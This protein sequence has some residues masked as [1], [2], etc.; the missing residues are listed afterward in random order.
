MLRFR[1]I[2]LDDGATIRR[3]LLDAPSPQLAGCFE[4]FYLWRQ[5]LGV[6]WA[7]TGGFALFKVRYTP[8]VPTFLF[9]AGP[10]DP[11]AA[12]RAVGAYCAAQGVP[13]RFSKVRA[14]QLEALRRVFPDA[15]AEAVRDEAEY[16]YNADTFRTY[17]GKALQPKRNFVNY[18]RAHFDWRYEAVG[19]ENLAECR[20]FAATFDGDASF[21]G[22]SAALRNALADW[23]RLSLHGGLIRVGGAVAALFVCT[24]GSDLHTAQ[25]LFLRGDHEKKGVIPLLYQIYFLHHTEFRA[26]NF[27]EDLGVEGLRKN[28]LSFQPTA[29]LD[30]YRVEG[31]Q[32]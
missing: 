29:M 7:E 19:P 17:T 18:A 21:A 30:L 12:L 28:K 20:A 15:R 32:F 27:G 6:E 16:L 26:F 10:G 5:V 4:A 13:L 24:M 25:G 23:A 22:D 2:S 9:P 11:S 31:C 1:P 8:D 3:A 14:D